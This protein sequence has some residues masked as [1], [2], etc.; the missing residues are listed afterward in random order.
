MKRILAALVLEVIALTASSA[1]PMRHEFESKHMGTSFRIVMV[2]DDPVKAA[3][4]V[5]EAFARVASLE[6]VMTDYRAD[7][8]VMTLCKR[9]DAEPGKQLPISDDLAKVLRRSLELSK[10]TDGSFDITVGPLTKLWR[11]SRKTQEHT[12]KADLDAALALVGCDKL[13]LDETA[14][15][16]TFNKA[17]MRLDFGGIGKGFA[18]DEALTVLKEKHGIDTVL[19]AAAGDITC[20]G[21]PHGKQGWLVE[22]APL[23]KGAPTR[24]LMLKNRS[25]STS[26]DLEQVAVIAGIRYSHVLNPKTGLGL[27]GRR[28]VTVVAGSGAEADALTKAASVLPQDKVAAL[29]EMLGNC[30]YYSVVQEHDGKSTAVVQSLGFTKLLSRNPA[31]K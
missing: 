30:E 9:N 18:V 4:A 19:M 6:Q 5:K 1:Q 11:I 29:F 26:G 14:K 21:T 8:E 2:H 24:S 23:R 28:S 20:R 17:G 12:P 31:E 7:S 13:R 10:Q 16:L 22:I 15:T 27:T 3:A 25:V